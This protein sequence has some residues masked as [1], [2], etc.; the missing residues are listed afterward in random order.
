[1]LFYQSQCNALWAIC[2]VWHSHGSVTKQVCELET[3]VVL[4]EHLHAAELL[5]QERVRLVDNL[6]RELLEIRAAR[7]KVFQ[8]FEQPN[9]SLQQQP[10]KADSKFSVHCS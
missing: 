4:E 7:E 1:M 10:D 2:S 8:L 9:I 6:Q 5:L 3:K